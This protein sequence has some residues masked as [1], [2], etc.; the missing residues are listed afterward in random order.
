MTT[1]EF[2]TAAAL[3]GAVPLTL[4]MKTGTLRDADGRL[5]FTRS[6]G[7]RLL[8]API[9]EIHSVAQSVM[10]ITLWHGDRRYRFAIGKNTVPL[11]GGTGLVGAAVAAVQLPNA[12]EQS[13]DNKYLALS[14]LAD[15]QTAGG[16]PPPGL[17]IK[18]P[19]KMWQ[20]LA[21]V[22]GGVL[23][24]VAVMVVIILLT[25]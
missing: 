24:L 11:R 16:Q 4:T 21:A 14:W 23:G 19:W 13:R 12:L 1:G 9:S 22:T 20:W 7:E 2:S 8:D 18:R 15:L 10:G 6:N 5:T 17:A 3:V 25:K